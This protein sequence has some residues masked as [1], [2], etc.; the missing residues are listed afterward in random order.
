M[1]MDLV[2]T[3]HFNTSLKRGQNVVIFLS[4]GRSYTLPKDVKEWED[5]LEFSIQSDQHITTDVIVNKEHIVS[6]ETHYQ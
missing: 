5:S 3:E 4:N 6:I 2:I 1:M